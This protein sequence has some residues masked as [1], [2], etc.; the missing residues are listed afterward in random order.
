V[1]TSV[2]IDSLAAKAGSDTYNIN[3]GY[4]TVDQD[5]RYGT[6]QNTS[7][8]MGNIA[9]SA[10]LGG[11]IEFNSTLVRIIPY[12][13]GTGNV[14]AYGTTISLGGASGILLGVYSALNAVPTAVGVA[15]PASGFIKIR[16]WNSVA[17][18][19]GALTGIGATA[20]GVDR[21]GWLEIVG[22]DALACTVNRLNT[23][24]VRGDWFDLGTTDGTRATTYQIPSNGAIVYLP[25]VWVETGTSTGIYE[26]Y[27]CAGSLTALAANVATDEVRGRFCW[28][29]T[30]G[31]LRFG[32][33]GT[34]LTGGFIPAAGRKVRIPN[35]FFMCCTSAALTAN[36]LPNA[37]LGTR[38]EFATTGGGVID[39]DKASVNWYCN[40]NQPYSV[41]LNNTG[42][43]TNLTV[44]ECAAPITWSHV[45]VGQEAAVSTFGLTMSLCFAGGIISNC[46]FSRATL[47]AT[48]QYA[49]SI[50][51]ISGFTFTNIRVHCLGGARG[52]AT[53]GC[54]TLTRASSCTWTSCLLAGGRNL[55]TTC[56]DCTFTNTIYYDH[57]ATTTPVTNPQ[58]C[59]DLTTNCLRVK[60]DGLTF[61]GLTLC[62]PYSGILSVGAAGCTDIDL[63][64]LGT[65]AAPLDLGGAQ[66]NAT[67]TRATTTA[68]ATKVAHG[69]KANDIVYVLISSDVAAITVA[70]KTVATVPT[71]DTFTFTCLNAGAASGTLVYYPTMSALLYTLAT[72][73]AANSVRI[74]RCYTPHTRTNLS[75]EDNSSKNIT[76]ESV[77][78]DYIGVPL[79]PALN[80][81]TKGVGSTPSLAG[82][83]SCYG[84]HWIDAF[85]A[86]VTPNLS[87]QAWTR[88]TTTATVTSTAHGLRTGLLINV[89]VTSSA[90]AIVLGQK[91]V[92]AVT[93]NTFTFTCLNAGSA[94]GTLT[95]APLTG[96]IGLL[97]NESTSD[98]ADQYTID[99]GTAAFTSAGGLYMPV[100]ADQTT[101]TT[102]YSILGHTYFPIAEAVMAGGTIG[103]YDITYSIDKNDGAGYSAFKNLAYPRAGG[104]GASAST[105]VTMT[106]TTGVAAGD[107]VWGTNI[108]P[109]AKVASITNSTTVVVDIANI[110]V[111]SGVLRFSQLPSETSINAQLGV[112]LKVRIKTTTTNATAITSLYF[113]TDSTDVSRAY[114]YVLDPVDTTVSVTDAA[115]NAAIANARVL[116]LAASGGD[117]PYNES[118]TIALDGTDGLTCTVTHTAHGLESGNKV[119]IRGANDKIYN[120]IFAITKLTDNSYSYVASGAVTV[121]APTGRYDPASASNTYVSTKISVLADLSGNGRNLIQAVDATRPVISTD[122]TLSRDVM[123]FSGAQQL[124]QSVENFHNLLGI[125]NWTVV[126]EGQVTSAPNAFSNYW[127]NPTFFASDG[128]DYSVVAQTSSD[129]IR[130]RVGYFDASFVGHTPALQSPL[131]LNKWSTVSDIKNATTDTVALDGLSGTAENIS[132]IPNRFSAGTELAVIGRGYS[133]TGLNFFTGKI[134]RVNL[135]NTALTQAQLDVV[136]AGM[137]ASATATGTVTATAVIIDGETDGYGQITEVRS[138]SGLTQPVSGRVRRATSSTMYK[139]TNVTGTVSSASGVTLNVQLI[140]DS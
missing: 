2:N 33:D 138:F 51:D 110:G 24:K 105:N 88:A 112:K 80:R 66:Q 30:A 59:F 42:I 17:Y 122:A 137:T 77:Y 13:T 72:G 140:Q 92:T 32:H 60:V 27:P 107:Y 139:T 1:T 11:T 87:A 84:T 81:T 48:G 128:Q 23:F 113:I 70:S 31:L 97:M 74:K 126:L 86:A 37:T 46:V 91:T 98:T 43:L 129:V 78:G 99:A 40:L 127:E 106:S 19:A 12:N 3:G 131:F 45:G 83:T 130:A 96:R 134:G 52:N 109:N 65:Y 104:G 6:N 39:I 56:T 75:T 62:Q 101:F 41:A 53:T 64:N 123:V 58:Y 73:A 49:T 82:Q 133:G 135:Y 14:P 90:A 9:L 85:I 125:T 38:Y 102:P 121:P 117:L 69:L 57:P 94:S 132:A 55:L 10:T 44:T 20:T 4:L 15:M 8:G 71:A 18:A 124:T 21:A 116:L 50:A 47:A 54:Q 89:T 118:V 103:N 100:I 5:T 93:A 95:F 22:V 108:A 119:L 114:Q 25:G 120:G 36:V 67:W 29:S 115:T 136:I 35:I 16:Q 79:T 34:N 7:A 111:V 68:T 63:R 61:G 28:I 26:F 76:L